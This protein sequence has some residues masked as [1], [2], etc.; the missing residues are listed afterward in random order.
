M[1]TLVII[2]HPDYQQSMSQQFLKESNQSLGDVTSH[3]LD[4]QYP[5]GEIDV[6]NELRLLSE[7]DRIIFQFPLY[8]YSSP[9]LLKVWQDQVLSQVSGST[10]KGKEL[11]LVVTVGVT[12]RSYRSG[13]SVGF[14]L[15][16]LMRPFQVVAS[17]FNMTYLSPL[18]IYQFAYQSEGAKFQLLTD[19]QYYLTGSPERSLTNRVSWLVSQ[20]EEAAT[21]SQEKK[22]IVMNHL[23]EQQETI[24][25]LQ[26]TID[27][28]ES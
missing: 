13:G 14:S 9:S 21:L 18:G 19:Y 15:D 16:E 12:E 7:H 10:L 27:E 5:T 3:H 26:Q 11:G 22:Q 1:K 8:W 25:D 23:E 6:A 28:M 24:D 2:S 20:L 4:S 17:Y